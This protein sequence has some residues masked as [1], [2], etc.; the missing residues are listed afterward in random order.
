MSALNASEVG[1]RPVNNI[2]DKL[3]ECAAHRK[4]NMLKGAEGAWIQM[5]RNNVCYAINKIVSFV[6]SIGFALLTLYLKY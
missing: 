4:L 1:L 6:L 5:R 3:K 2:D